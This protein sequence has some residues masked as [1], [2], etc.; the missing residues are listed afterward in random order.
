MY[1][2]GPAISFLTCFWLFPQ[3]EYESRFPASGNR[4][5]YS[6]RTDALNH[7]IRRVLQP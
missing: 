5:L 7:L 6:G 4:P 3:N 1:A 2:L